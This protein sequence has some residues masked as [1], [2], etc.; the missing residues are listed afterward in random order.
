LWLPYA[1]GAALNFFAGNAI[2][3]SITAE[4]DGLACIFY[5]SAGAIFCGASHMIIMSYREGK[6]HA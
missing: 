3:S 4:V 1:L 2:I 5:L 6:W